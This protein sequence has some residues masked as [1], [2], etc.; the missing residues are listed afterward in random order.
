MYTIHQMIKQ[1]V[2]KRSHF[3]GCK[4]QSGDMIERCSIIK[5]AKRMRLVWN[6]WMAEKMKVSVVGVCK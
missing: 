3:D 4:F 6:R 5:S 1:F 2:I